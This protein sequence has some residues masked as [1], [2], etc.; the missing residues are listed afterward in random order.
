MQIPIL[1]DLPVAGNNC[2]VV[3]L[4]GEALGRMEISESVRP[5]ASNSVSAGFSQP[6]LP[7]SRPTPDI[8]PPDPPTPNL[9]SWVSA[10]PVHH[11]DR[12][13]RSETEELSPALQ[14]WV[15]RGIGTESRRDG[16]VEHATCRPSRN[17]VRTFTYRHAMAHMHTCD[18]VYC[19]FS[20][21]DRANLISDPPRLWQYIAAVAREKKILLLA[22][23]GTTNH[24]HLLIALPPTVALAKAVQELK[25]N[26]S[27]WLSEIGRPFAWQQG[28]SAFSVSQSQRETVIRYIDNQTV[29]PREMDVRAGISDAVTEVRDCV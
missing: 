6:L 5:M 28:Y 13:S 1:L 20:T 29:A 16:R 17:I 8:A 23:G 11:D 21:N 10:G 3:V 2:R 22:A 7:A 27:R 24:L 18:L 9:G 12:V 15:G 26:T 4:R 19:V 14:R 25:G